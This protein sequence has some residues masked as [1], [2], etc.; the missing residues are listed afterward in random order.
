MP[1]GDAAVEISALRKSYRGAP[2]LDGVDLEIWPGEIFALLGPNAAGKTTTVE[3]CEGFR[4]G[5]SG[6]VR[7]LGADPRRAGRGWRSRIGIVAQRTDDFGELSVSEAVA[8]MAGYF[9]EPRA[10]AEVVDAVGLRPMRRARCDRLSPDQRR[11]LEIALGIIGRPEL[12]FLDEPTAGFEAD[13]RH[14]FWRLIK[15]LNADGT[16][17]LLTTHYLGEVEHLAHRVGV[18]A[19]GRVLDVGTPETIGGRSE[20]AA[21]VR[22]IGPDGPREQQTTAPTEL[23]SKLASQFGGEVPGLVVERPTLEDVYV[24]M[25]ERANLVRANLTTTVVA[26]RDDI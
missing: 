9:A 13:A 3:I 12:L 21:R 22:W 2:A 10:V 4:C 6:D 1:V 24:R 19:A 5:D 15:E 14:E 7:V 26:R 25:I 20:A 18:M 23:V 16:T 8:T 11:R 17:I